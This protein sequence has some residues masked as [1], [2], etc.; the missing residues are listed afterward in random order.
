M[1]ELAPEQRVASMLD[2][3]ETT[4]R[5]L[6]RAP[7]PEERAQRQARY[8]EN[9]PSKEKLLNDRLRELHSRFEEQARGQGIDLDLSASAPREARS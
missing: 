1:L 5:K 7:S 8:I 4:E 9:L 2:A 3:W 6:R